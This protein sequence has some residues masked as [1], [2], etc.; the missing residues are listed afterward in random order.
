MQVTICR[1]AH[2]S[3]DSKINRV[4]SIDYMRITLAAPGRPHLIGRYRQVRKVDTNRCSASRLAGASLAPV[5]TVPPPNDEIGEP[6]DASQT[7]F[8]C[9]PDQR[10]RNRRRSPDRREV[11][12]GF[13]LFP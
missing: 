12:P 3:W 13:A 9:R 10:D 5:L 7:S 4:I 11:G 6:H 2:K 1:H 8:R